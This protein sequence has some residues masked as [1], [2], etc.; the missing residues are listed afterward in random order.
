MMN[1]DGKFGYL[2]RI[3]VADISA[4]SLF[5][6]LLFLRLGFLSISTRKRAI[7]IYDWF[8]CP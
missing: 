2:R 7:V 8:S 3:G 4:P 5:I 1:G 6:F